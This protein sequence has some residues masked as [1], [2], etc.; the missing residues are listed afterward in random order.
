MSN[1]LQPHRLYSPW[2]SSGQDIG[3][4]FSV[5]PNPGI[6]PR[7]PALQVDS[8]PAELSRKPFCLYELPGM[9]KVVKTASWMLV[10]P[11][12]GEEWRKSL[13][14]GYGILV[15][16]EDVLDELG[17]SGG[18]TTLWTSWTPLGLSSYKWLE[19]QNLH[20]AYFTAIKTKILSRH[21]VPSIIWMFDFFYLWRWMICYYKVCV[22]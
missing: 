5:D 8:L 10:V 6:K 20:Y 18:C 19:W 15:L 12:W 17:S 3:V 16:D 4:P 2:N 11:G 9:G 7:S 22:N 13:W 21:R 14:S 1:S